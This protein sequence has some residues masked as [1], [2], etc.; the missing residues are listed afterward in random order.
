MLAFNVHPRLRMA[1]LWDQLFQSASE[2]Q[3][4]LPKGLSETILTCLDD[5][6]PLQT[7]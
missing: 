6:D 7:T 5:L 3:V 4:M 1:P 2:Q